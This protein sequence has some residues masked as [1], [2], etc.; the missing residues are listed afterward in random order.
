MTD[1]PLAQKTVAILAAN[2]FEETEMTEPQRGLLAAGAVVKLVSPEQALVN[3]WHGGSWGHYFP[4][5]VPLSSALA[6]DFDALIVPGGERSVQKLL[7]TPHTQRFLKGF[8]D[9]DKPVAV[10][11]GS[12]NLLATADRA[13]GRKLAADETS[14]EALGTAGAETL[15]QAMVTDGA[16]ISARDDVEPDALKDEVLRVFGERL[17]DMAE[18]EAA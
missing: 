3:G 13:K 8:M 6:A 17:G 5:D 4:V 16:L 2:G 15:D 10:I 7:G 14:A 11:G 12:I 1:K 9:G 18:A